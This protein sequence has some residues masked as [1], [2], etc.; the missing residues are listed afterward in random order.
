[1]V[2]EAFRA[3]ALPFSTVQQGLPAVEK[4]VAAEE[5]MVPTMV[6]PPV[7]LMVAALP[8]CQKTFFGWAPPARMTLRGSPA[9]PTVSVLAIWKIQTP[10]ALP[11][12]S[13]VR[14]DPVI[15]NAPPAL[16]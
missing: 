5:I 12:A 10:L 16:L 9:P 13:R 14:S 8:T 3:K 2:T 6:P 4:V 1:M 7:P 11:P 15:R